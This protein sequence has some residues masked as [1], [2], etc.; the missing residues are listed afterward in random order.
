MILLKR[1]LEW[2][3]RTTKEKQMN[4]QPEMSNVELMNRINY[5]KHYGESVEESFL[6]E[7]KKRGLID[8]GGEDIK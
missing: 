1:I 2:I 3:D 7:A 5:A 6:L 4:E 8:D